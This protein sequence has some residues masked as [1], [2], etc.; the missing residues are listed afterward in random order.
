MKPE[1]WR[2]ETMQWRQ[3]CFRNLCLCS[4]VDFLHNFLS[5]S[6]LTGLLALARN[7]VLPR[8]C[9]RSLYASHSDPKTVQ[10]ILSYDYVLDVRYLLNSYIIILAPYHPLLGIPRTGPDFVRDLLYANDPV[11]YCTTR[12]SSASLL[13]PLCQ[14][15]TPVAI[16]T[17]N[18][19]AQLH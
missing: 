3:F 11:R 10:Q 19:P 17:S 4:F 16:T 13:P 14:G 9:I 18:R 8:L 12:I 1:A 6:P 15:F 5:D 7:N 2:G